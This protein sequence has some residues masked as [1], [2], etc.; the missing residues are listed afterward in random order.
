MDENC[1]SVQICQSGICSTPSCTSNFMGSGGV[2]IPNNGTLV[3]SHGILACERGFLVENQ[4]TTSIVCNHD[5]QWTVPRSKSI[6]RCDPGCI[7][8]RDCSLMERCHQMQCIPKTCSADI[9]SDNLN[10]V[11][12]KRLFLLRFASH[13]MSE[14]LISNV[15]N[16]AIPISNQYRYK[17][18]WI[19]LT[20]RL[21]MKIMVS[22]WMK[23]I[24]RK[25]Q[26]LLQKLPN[27][28]FFSSFYPYSKGILE[29]MRCKKV[30][31][32]ICRSVFPTPDI[33][34]EPKWFAKRDFKFLDPIK[35]ASRFNAKPTR[36]LPNGELWTDYL[37]HLVFNLVPKRNVRPMSAVIHF[38]DTA[39]HFSVTTKLN[40]IMEQSSK[41]ERTSRKDHFICSN[42]ILGLGLI[43]PL[44]MA[45]T[46]RM[47][48]FC[49]TKMYLSTVW[50][51]SCLTEDLYLN[52]FQV[53]AH[54]HPHYQL[55]R[56]DVYLYWSMFTSA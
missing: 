38:W 53:R 29:K 52:V 35:P 4:K 5:R 49:A 41:L 23:S 6:P 32:N 54:Q 12:K 20:A 22:S 21:L 24:T 11:R 25:I 44:S 26:W 16:P 9:L 31:W 30:S 13:I 40:A 15:D 36:L 3:G 2:I 47:W 48:R 50:I 45:S 28:N 18:P 51:G 7:D 34:P 42:V 14:K 39:Y 43:P 33:W 55:S 10:S 1:E 19:F 37:C 56:M 17:S 46:W 27:S 8:D